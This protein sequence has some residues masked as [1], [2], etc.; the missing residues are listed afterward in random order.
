MPPEAVASKIEKRTRRWRPTLAA[1]GQAL[2]G[3]YNEDS[4]T[5]SASIAY[6][7]VLS[8]FPLLLLMLELSGLYISHYQLA[9]RLGIILERILPMKPDF[10]MRNLQTI[11]RNYGR[12]GVASFLLLLWSSAGVFLPIEKSLN[13]AWGVEKDR[14][15]WQRRLLALEMALLF[16]ILAFVSSDLVGVAAYLHHWAQSRW[17]GALLLRIVYG[18][19]QIL[20]S[21][22]V[23]LAMFAV[24]FHALPNRRIRFRQVLPSAV[25][26]A[27][28]WQL[29]RSLFTFLFHRIN[30]QHVYGSIGATVAFMTWAYVSAAIMLFGARASSLLYRTVA[31]PLD[32]SAAE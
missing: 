19:L 17:A 28:L 2:L 24:L 30:Y 23:V 22:A 4:L 12:V 27:L 6:Y 7:S 11:T 25:L 20:A 14:P 3:F 10:I 29:A 16:G 26:T 21:F 9:G 1:L 13:R 31:A 8:T 5:V 18:T 15:W 32:S